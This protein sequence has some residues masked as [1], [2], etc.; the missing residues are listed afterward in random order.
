M[1]R[2]YKLDKTPRRGEYLVRYHEELNE[3]QLAV[4]EAGL[5]PVLV[6]AGAGSGKT[7]ALTYRVSRLIED[8]TR[9]SSILLL[10]FTN[11]A[12]REMLR[13]VEDLVGGDSRQI[14]GGTFHS[15]GNRIIRPRA[16]SLGYG[17]NFSILDEDDAR[18]LMDSVVE[19]VGVSTLERRFPK[20]EVLHA[21]HSKMINTGVHLEDELAK[22][23]EHFLSYAEEIAAVFRR[24]RE[25]KKESNVMDFDDLLLNWWHLLARGDERARELQGL[26]DHV[27]VDE[28]QDTNRLQ[29][30]IV[31]EMV[32]VRRN[33]VV[34]GDDAQSIYSFRGASF[35]NVITFPVRYPDAAVLKL[36]KNYRSSPQILEL[37]NASL[38]MNRHQFP[39]ELI[40]VRGEGPLPALVPA[41]D[42]FEQARFV[43]QRILELRDEGED[44]SEIA[45]LYRSHY[46][47]M[48][49]QME[50]QRRNIPFEI[51]SGVRFFEQAHIKDVVAHLRITVNPRDE[52]SWR[53][54]LEL[55]PKV[56]K[57]T[58]SAVWS[59]IGTASDPISKFTSSAG[60]LGSGGAKRSLERAGRLLGALASP[61]L[62]SDPAAAIRKVV[63]E[64]YRD[65][66][67]SKFANF[68]ARLDDLE[69]LA[70]YAAGWDDVRIFLESL[71]LDGTTLAGEDTAITGSEDERVVLSSA[72]QAKG[73]EWRNVFVIGLNESRFPSARAMR[74][75]QFVTI[76]KPKSSPVSKEVAAL[77]PADVEPGETVELEIPGVEEE[78][79]LF[80]VC[81]TR[82]KQELHLV[83]PRFTKDRWQMDVILEP[84]RFLKELPAELMEEWRL[85]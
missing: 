64:D 44:L 38:S 60:S 68:S 56:G 33:L 24:Y 25:K 16:E 57:R 46:Q 81:V 70:Q 15:M 41:E 52:L 48:E 32:A 49:L 28:Y 74:E 19:E 71:T 83:F 78:R 10:T 1:V 35:E 69:Q 82:A 58:A 61:G 31:D 43:G 62:Q 54:V 2:T 77:V 12:A 51:R 50:L 3:E 72:H 63:E 9:P 73:L 26:F 67:R 7:R 20:G 85:G 55:Y 80:Y 65:Y 36:E 5:G 47:A 23:H 39:K 8:G 84:S 17:S 21:I 6:I 14:Q 40:A 59:K 29:A 75:S 22:N 66:V 18:T 13:R 53:R 11:K 37:A 34:V 27:L 30:K 76:E 79:R 42:V 4:V 45:V